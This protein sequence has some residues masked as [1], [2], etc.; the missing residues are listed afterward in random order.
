MPL[1]PGA[2]LG[3]YEVLQP[4]GAG[5]MGE[6][7]RAR[8]T[9]LQRDVAIKVLP[10]RLTQNEQALAR[11]ERE[12]RVVAALSHPNILA[13]HDVG[14]EGSTAFAVMEL[15]EGATLRDELREGPLPAR[16]AADY[17]AQAAEGLAAAH[18]KAVVHRDLKPENL[19][20]TRDGRLKILD[21]GLAREERRPS[22]SETE[23]PT[24]VRETDPGSVVGTVGY[25]SPEQVR[26]ELVDHRSDIFSLGCVLHEML[27]GRRAFGRETAAETMTAILRE[28][29]HPI[30]DS[31]R[32]IPPGLARIVSH[33]LEKKPEQRFQSARDLAF[34]LASISGSSETATS[35]APPS[36]RGSAWRW[37]AAATTVGVL[38][39]ALGYWAGRT[40]AGRDAAPVATTRFSQVTDLAGIETSPSLSPDGKTLA[41][42]GRPSGDFDI[43]VQRVGGHNPV[44]LTDD[45]PKDDTAPAFSPDGD[46]L[47][48]HSECEGGG[49]FV[50]GATGESRRRIAE[51]GHDPSWSPDGR[52][53]VAASEQ[54]VSPLSRNA[55]SRLSIVD[56]ASGTARVLLEQD[57]MQPAWSPDGRRI[58]FWGLR[59][60][61]GGTGRRDIWTVPAEGGEA[62]EVTRDEFVDWSPTWSPDARHLYFSSGRGGTLNLWR[63]RV[64]TATGA[65]GGDAE[66]VTTPAR[67]SGPLTLSREGARLAFEAREQRSTLHRVAFDPEREQLAGAPELVLGGSHQIGSIG[68]SPDGAWVTLATFGLLENIFLI[69]L[70]G[71]G[72]R[73]LTDDG[74]RNRGSSFSADGSLISFYSNRSGRYE[75]WNL[76]RDGSNL[77]QI[78][79]SESG[80][81]WF[82][83]WS[84]DGSRIAIS[85]IPASQLLDP[86][87]PIG[88]RAV[89]EFPVPPDGTR[90][91]PSSWFPDGS[92]VAGATLRPD[93]SSA[94]VV[95]FDLR[96]LSYVRLTSSGTTTQVLRD[97]RRLLYEDD[98]LIRLLDTAS[99]RTTEILRIGRPNQ[100]INQ[101]LFRITRDNRQIVFIRGEAES[102]IWLMGT[103]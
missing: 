28:D 10:E 12:A 92:R 41:F 83:E 16:R 101:R 27:S 86:A 98:G 42:A 60:G 71:T 37:L 44:N 32:A 93:G 14:Q 11:F 51:Q 52:S 58:A 77:E 80:S 18:E 99:G 94:G 33:C 2:R 4:I 74:F 21:F 23:S 63:I 102:D 50:M 39:L 56:V 54:S 95:V 96:S 55:E 76:R 87:K 67:A 73:Q 1:A 8:D 30:A 91:Q 79:R 7:Y 48:Y 22:G 100:S 38:L 47:V 82:P 3:P 6:V 78:T 25:M 49:L 61:P 84:P 97:G 65:L 17:A 90:F 35:V 20:V 89:F 103:E 66:P 46:R 13:I 62:V 64:D 19:F 5:G 72:Y 75:I 53:V 24:L 70:D 88:A 43:Y 69:R 36:G 40:V 68:L 15:L 59:G 29:A 34:D 45:C 85:G 81:R 57:A 9:R 26:G 31:G